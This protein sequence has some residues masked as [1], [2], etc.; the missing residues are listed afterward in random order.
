MPARWN[1]RPASDGAAR[2]AES[3]GLHPMLGQL[4]VNRGVTGA[5][6]ANR[7]LS[8]KLTGLHDPEQLPGA[9]DAAER[10]HRAVR[11]G[12]SICIY[13]DYD[14]DGMCASAIL[15]QA[16]LLAGAKARCYVPDRLEEGYGLN[17]EALR[18][19]KEEGI[20]T[21][22]TVDCG[23][24]AA[25]EAEVAREIGLELIVTDHHE[26]D[27]PVPAADVL[28]H[29]RRPGG[30]YPFGDLCGTGVAYKLAWQ[31][32]R[33]LSGSQMAT[34]AFRDFLLDATTLAAIGTVCDI[35]PLVDENRILVHHGLLSLKDRAPLGLRQLMIVAG[36]ADKRKLTAGDIGFTIGPR[37]NA[38]GRLGQARLGVELLTT[39]DED[40]ARQ[41]AHHL[42]EQNK[43]RQTLERRIFAEAKDM[44]EAERE[45]RGGLP[46]AIVLASDQW[47][48]GVI[49]IVA[50]RIVERFHRP[51]VL[52]A[53]TADRGTGSGRSI[54][55]F[56]L[57]EA[58]LECRDLLL[59]AGGHE[60]AAG[61]SIDAKNLDAF[62]T[63]LCDLAAAGIPDE[64]LTAELNVDLEMPLHLLTTR[65]V[66]TLDA[67]EPFGLRNPRPLFLATGLSVVDE[68]RCVGGGERH[69]SFKV[70]Q[71][72]TQ[73][74]A[75]AFGM[76]ERV[77]ELMSRGGDCCIVFQPT[78]NEWRGRRTAELMVKDFRPG[79]VVAP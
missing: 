39:T 19:L 4:L 49:G 56:H 28:V 15:S 36:L 52:I 14:V 63:R 34:G 57:Q 75:I 30:E 26:F 5:D 13:G 20:D 24:T 48:A 40:R 69:L 77:Q 41:I 70:S 11:D 32:A 78:V 12:R 33:K 27:G 72:R 55:G 8:R 50:S 66:D 61:L 45:S 23:A 62:R 17:A 76:A 65:L 44:V 51:T 25:A 54:G 3:I 43:Q 42:E 31:F 7:F 46:P 60:M 29:P 37:L 22:V 18:N 35:V 47:H 9:D 2:L 64:R 68:P 79:G 10:L 6:D 74:K 67:M 58:L 73:T 38:C 21:V 1:I 53:L 71:G 16:L 59:K